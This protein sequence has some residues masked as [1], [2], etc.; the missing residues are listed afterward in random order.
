MVENYIVTLTSTIGVKIDLREYS[1]RDFDSFIEYLASIEVFPE[2]EEELY[3]CFA[4]YLAQEYVENDGKMGH[5]SDCQTLSVRADAINIVADGREELE[6]TI[7]SMRSEIKHA[8][9]KNKSDSV[10]EVYLRNAIRYATRELGDD[11][12]E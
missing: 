4:V 2:T 3:E 8:L 1:S 11:E 5:D 7:R 12:D 10:K 6:S 9:N